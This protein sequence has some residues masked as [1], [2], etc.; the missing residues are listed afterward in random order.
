MNLSYENLMASCI[1]AA[2]DIAL[3]EAKTTPL[4][5]GAH[6]GHV[7][8]E[9]YGPRWGI[10]QTITPTEATVEM[11]DGEI[12]TWE[13]E[14]MVDIERVDSL[15]KENQEKVMKEI[16]LLNSLD[17]NNNGVALESNPMMIGGADLPTPGCDCDHCAT[18][19]PEQHEQARLVAEQMGLDID[20]KS[21]TYLQLK[22]AA[23]LN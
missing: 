8:L 18:F 22:A 14:G 7:D 16:M 21:S 12:M 13:T 3:Q 19:T 1:M 9:K 11:K 15:I 4:T 10:L 23:D 6:V 2:V 5:P 17:E 20:P